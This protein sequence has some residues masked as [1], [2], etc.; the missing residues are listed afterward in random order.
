MS[1]FTVEGPYNIPIE[2]HPGGR[3]I[4]KDLGSFWTLTG[5]L[6]ERRGCYVFAFRV[7][8]GYKPVYVGKATKGFEQECFAHHKIA[9]H[10]YPALHRLANRPPV[11]F[12]IC[13][14]VRKGKP[15]ESEIR[16]IESF[17][18]KLAAAKN[19][20]LSNVKGKKL[21]EWSI[22][23]V[24]RSGKGKPTGAAKA[25]KKMLGL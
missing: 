15:N 19:P 1:E 4:P 6:G 23:G 17:L 9:S 16:D 22:Q 8:K 21:P 2:K 18:T 20:D 3:T 10:Y 14:E 11:M 25:L 24:V 7:G 12:F 5:N 13:Q